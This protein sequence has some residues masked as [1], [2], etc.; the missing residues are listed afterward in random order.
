MD[1]EPKSEVRVPESPSCLIKHQSYLPRSR[2]PPLPSSAGTRNLLPRNRL[3]ILINT[4]SFHFRPCSISGHFLV[5]MIHFSLLI[6]DSF[7]PWFFSVKVYITEKGTDPKSVYWSDIVYSTY[8]KMC[9]GSWKMRSNMMASG[10]YS[11]SHPSDSFRR[12]RT[13]MDGL[14]PVFNLNC[15]ERETCTKHFIWVKFYWG[16]F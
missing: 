9:A 15:R 6:L 5:F 13:H 4:C 11:W 16:W 10:S 7:P 2:H 14:Q 1:H 3:F 12:T 8:R